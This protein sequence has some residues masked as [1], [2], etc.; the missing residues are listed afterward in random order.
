MLDEKTMKILKK[1]IHENY[2]NFLKLSIAEIKQS[3]NYLFLIHNAILIAIIS[4]KL[5]ITTFV[6][7]ITIVNSINIIIIPFIHLYYSYTLK[8]IAL[9]L[10]YTNIQKIDKIDN[11]SNF[12][13]KKVN[14]VSK[15]YN[16]ISKYLSFL[17]YMVFYL[18]I[19]LIIV[20]ILNKG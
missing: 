2:A 3:L 14:N 13:E 17:V 12:L 18:T 4:F 7:F 19:A 16:K 20:E 5:D 8:Q 6:K 9:E 11:I 1:S 15:T 10:K